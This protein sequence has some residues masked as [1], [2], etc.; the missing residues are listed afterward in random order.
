MTSDHR[1]FVDSDVI[2][3]SLLSNIGAAYFLLHKAN[4][5]LFI[6]DVSFRELK[7]VTKRLG[8]VAVKLTALVEKKFT[9]VKLNKNTSEIKRSYGKY[10][11]DENDAHIAAGASTAK[12]KFLI[13]YKL[14]DFKADYIKRDF[15]IICMKPAHFLQYLRSLS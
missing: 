10:T 7:I 5:E 14:R 11:H 6:S 8:L 15:G 4:L 9:I 1:V 12:A 2:I 3:S 13:T